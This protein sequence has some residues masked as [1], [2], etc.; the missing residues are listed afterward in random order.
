MLGVENQTGQNQSGKFVDPMPTTHLSSVALTVIATVLAGCGGG[1]AANEAEPERTIT[2][3]TSESTSLPNDR[4]RGE[5]LL[6]VLNDTYGETR[7]IK[8][9]GL[10]GVAVKTDTALVYTTFTETLQTVPG[11]ELCYA[12]LDAGVPGVEHAKV[13]LAQ[14][15]SDEPI[16]ECP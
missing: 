6:A 12:A 5:Q 2:V 14:E 15:N 1:A 7:F 8:E 3:T 10:T 11:R 4:E 16:T 13:F 9:G